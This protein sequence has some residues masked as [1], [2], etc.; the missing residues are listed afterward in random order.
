MNKKDKLIKKVRKINLKIEKL[1]FKKSTILDEVRRIE[2][3]TNDPKS[4]IV[5]N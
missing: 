5:S 3:E 1:K 2:N 4:G